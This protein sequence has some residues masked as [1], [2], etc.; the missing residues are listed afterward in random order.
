ML[1]SGRAHRRSGR[2]HGGRGLDRDWDFRLRLGIEKRIGMQRD[3]ARTARFFVH[4]KIR[5]CG[6]DGSAAHA[7]EL[8]GD[9]ILISAGGAKDDG[10]V[11]G[12]IA[13]KCL[14]G[15]FG[16][17]LGIGLCGEALSCLKSGSDGI[18]TGL[19]AAHFG[20]RLLVFIHE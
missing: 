18:G 20:M 10:N 11:V 7:A 13:G 15:I 14:G 8:V 9:A 6:F 5:Y 19:G 4:R 2:A 3:G 16:G 1:R 17:L 12:K